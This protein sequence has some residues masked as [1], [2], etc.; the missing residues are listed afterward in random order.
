[1]IKDVQQPA[2]VTNKGHTRYITTCVDF[3]EFQSERDM[4]A[5]KEYGTSAFMADFDYPDEGVANN[6]EDTFIEG[7]KGESRT[8]DEFLDELWDS[9]KYY[10]T[11]SYETEVDIEDATGEVVDVDGGCRNPVYMG[12]QQ[13]F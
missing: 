6:C 1:M 2:Y 4:L 8:V 11:M 10:Y 9:G 5:F 13:M 12:R 3:C 7:V